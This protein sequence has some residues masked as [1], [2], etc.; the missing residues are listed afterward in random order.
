MQMACSRGNDKQLAHRN[1]DLHERKKLQ[2]ALIE[3][4]KQLIAEEIVAING[5]AERRGL[6]FDSTAT[7]LRFKMI[8]TTDGVPVRLMSDV[9]VRYKAAL[10]TGDVCYNSDSTGLLRFT[11]GQSDLPSGLQEGLLKMKEGEE[12]LMI[13][14]SYL[15]YGVSGD[16][17]CIPGSSS[18]FYSVKVESVINQ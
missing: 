4:N 17:R 15:A 2:E 3:Q 13:V 7:G 5:F 1:A 11:V 16:G 10:L 6:Q 9:S 18:I 14:P 12:A 8:K